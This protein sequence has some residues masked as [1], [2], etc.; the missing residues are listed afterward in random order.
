[1]NHDFLARRGAQP[2]VGRGRAVERDDDRLLDATE[3]HEGRRHEVRTGR[4][5]SQTVR[6]VV[7]GE[8][9]LGSLERGPFRCDSHARQAAAGIVCHPA[10]DGT[11]RLGE[12]G[13]S[14]EGGQKEERDAGSSHE[15]TS[16]AVYLGS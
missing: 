8:G 10:Y 13:R 3:A 9:R 6:A 16:F 15:G 5:E 1:M 14:E 11:R 2:E 12:E 7:L 4:K